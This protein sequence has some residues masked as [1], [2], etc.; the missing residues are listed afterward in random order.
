MNRRDKRVCDEH[1]QLLI[2][3][4]N[5]ADKYVQTLNI[6]R[7]LRT[8]V[9]AQVRADLCMIMWNVPLPPKDARRI[10]RVLEKAV[11]ALGEVL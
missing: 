6:Q 1:V 3:S 10:K 4:R 7:L 8:E 2:K 11:N 5:V 9:V